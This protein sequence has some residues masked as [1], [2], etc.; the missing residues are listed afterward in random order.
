[1]AAGTDVV[2]RKYDHI[3][4]VLYNLHC[5][6]IFYMIQ[7]KVLVLIFKALHGMVPSYLPDLIHRKSDS[8]SLRSNAKFL[9]DVPKGLSLTSAGSGVFSYVRTVLFNALTQ[10]MKTVDNLLVSKCKHK[11]HL[12]NQAF[13]H[14]REYDIWIHFTF[15]TFIL[16]HVWVDYWPDRR[17]LYQCFI[18]L[19]IE[20]ISRGKIFKIHQTYTLEFTK[21]WVN[22]YLNNIT[23]FYIK[24]KIWHQFWSLKCEWWHRLVYQTATHL[25][26]HSSHPSMYL[27]KHISIMGIIWCYIYTSTLYS[28]KLCS[29]TSTDSHVYMS[30]TWD[31]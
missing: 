18:L 7:Y 14:Y 10:C 15:V 5:L 16:Q 25:D 21:Y 13:G 31:E 2:K 19:L 24:N 17:C 29:L 1:M 8:K 22:L 6:P 9:L 23:I 12:F 20:Y 4:L 28:V 30:N 11:I 26:W 27:M 3:I